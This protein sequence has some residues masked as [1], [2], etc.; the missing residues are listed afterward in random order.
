[1]SLRDQLRKLD[2]QARARA[3]HHPE[4][5]AAPPEPSID[6]TERVARPFCVDEE[7][8]PGVLVR[9]SR[10]AFDEHH[11]DECLRDVLGVDRARI[12]IAG[13]IGAPLELERALFLDTETTSLEGGASA[14][15]FL[16]GIARITDRD[17]VVEQILLEAPEAEARFLARVAE[18]LRQHTQLVTFFG[19]AFD[20]HRLDERF[21]FLGGDEI[22]KPMPHLDLYW[23]ARRMFD[24]VLRDGKLRTLE[25]RRLGVQRVR[26][27][28]G[29]QCPEAWFDWITGI[30]RDR[31]ERAITHNLHDVV[32][33][34]A[35]LAHVDR[36]LAT[37]D[38]PRI[39]AGAGRLLLDVKAREL[40]IPHLERALEA[41]K[42]GLM[43]VPDA[44]RRAA[45][46]LATHRRRVG[47]RAGAIEVWTKLA[48]ANE[49]DPEPV[50]L[51]L[52]EAKRQRQDATII[53]QHANELRRR[54]LASPAGGAKA[55]AWMA[56]ARGE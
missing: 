17:L 54:L 1:M 46:A 15:V 3:R 16:V 51:L 2:D 39:A 36:S 29:A 31:L 6:R 34:V 21:A 8:E 12:G 13:R 18:R 47:D 10:Y 26:D 41:L 27:L 14:Y 7:R 56:A 49:G 35:L 22:A 55:R 24:P 4:P 40:A 30:G 48:R 9:T 45:L 43:L 23:L 42:P 32:S 5:F 25:E 37:P 53:Q 38:D 52:Q 20:R 44:V 33:L 50:A 11:G 28:D 19:K